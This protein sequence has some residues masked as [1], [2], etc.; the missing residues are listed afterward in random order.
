LTAVVAI[1]GVSFQSRVLGVAQPVN[2]AS[3]DNAPPAW[4]G[5]PF[6]PSVARGVFQPL[7]SAA[8]VSVKPLLNFAPGERPAVAF[9][10]DAASL[11]V[12]VGHPAS[13]AA[14]VNGIPKPLPF[15]TR[16]F[17]AK[18]RASH[19]SKPSPSCAMLASGVGQPP[20][21]LPDVRRPDARSAQIGG[22]DSIS[23]CF[24]VSSYSGEP[25]AAILAR[26]LF[27][28]DDWRLALVDEAAELRPQVAFV[29]GSL[30]LAGGAEG[31]AGT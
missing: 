22:P 4:F 25:C 20:K 16:A 26:N 9:L 3:A 7:S 15:P 30:V 11:A 14:I 10:E 12:V 17:V 23:Q 13:C 18:R 5:P 8:S 29:C 28:K 24:Q 31:L 2:A 27:S 21:P 6:D 1:P 19:V